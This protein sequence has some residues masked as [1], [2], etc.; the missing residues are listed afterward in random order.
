M[1]A[2]HPIG[3]L[4]AALAVSP[5]GYYDWQRR[6]AQPGP[7]AQADQSLLREIRTLHA[8]SRQ[9]YGSPRLQ[10]LLRRQG[11]VHGRNRIARLMRLAGL[12]GRSRRRYRPQTTDSQHAWPLAPNRL[13]QAAPVRAPNQVWVADVTYIPTGEGWLY[14]AGVLDLYSRQI[15]GWA[16]S[17]HNDTALVLAAWRMAIEHRQPP[18]RLLFHSDRGSSYASSAFRQALQAANVASSMSRAGNC[19]DNATMESFWSTLKWELVYRTTFD[20]RQ[21]AQAELFDYIEVFYNRQRLHS[22]LN[23]LCPVDFELLNN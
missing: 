20:T 14:L 11:R 22:A 18:A 17:Q 2:E 1:K 19:Y 6:Q 13:A 3:K 4:C 21:Q 7:R 23:Y 8:Q 12:C 5:S 15:V 9:T 10:V 16:M